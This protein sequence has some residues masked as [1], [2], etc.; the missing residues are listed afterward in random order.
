MERQRILRVKAESFHDRLDF[1]AVPYLEHQLSRR[2]KAGVAVEGQIKRFFE[3]LRQNISKIPAFG[4]DFNAVSGK[5]VGKQQDA[6]ALR[7]SAAMFLGQ[8]PADLRLGGRGKRAC[9]GETTFPNVI[10]T[11]P[12]TNLRLQP[13]AAFLIDLLGHLG[14]QSLHIRRRRAAQ[15]DG[16]VTVRWKTARESWSARIL[17]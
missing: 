6:E 15:I 13:D 1:I 5:I 17:P 14:Q 12:D 8:N 3:Q 11:L 10:Y 9:H 16:N 4:D 2:R 7:Q